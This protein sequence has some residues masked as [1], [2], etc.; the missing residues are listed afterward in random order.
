MTAPEKKKKKES[1]RYT[2]I[3]LYDILYPV[4]YGIQKTMETN[5]RK[6]VTIPAIKF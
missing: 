3:Y 5:S 4:V 6:T 1:P 2:H